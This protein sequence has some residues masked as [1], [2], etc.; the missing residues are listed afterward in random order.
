MR[1]PYQDA[2]Q[3]WNHQADKPDAARDR[4]ERANEDSLEHKY[5]C[6]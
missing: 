2:G 1:G 5:L 4:N 3:V 6:A